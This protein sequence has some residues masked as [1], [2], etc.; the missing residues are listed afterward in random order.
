ME[1][2]E[3][4]VGGTTHVEDATTE[5]VSTHSASKAK[6]RANGKANQTVTFEDR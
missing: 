1:L 4:V 3:D 5:S 2:W 6:A